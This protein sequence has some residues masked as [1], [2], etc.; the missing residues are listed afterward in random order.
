MA[1]LLSFRLLRKTG[2]GFAKKP[3]PTLEFEQVPVAQHAGEDSI[4]WFP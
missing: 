2:G 3:A 1:R 4:A